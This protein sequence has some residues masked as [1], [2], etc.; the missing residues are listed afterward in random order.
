MMDDML[1]EHI[2]Q[3]QPKYVDEEPTYESVK[4]E[5]EAESLEEIIQDE[6]D[7]RNT[8]MRWMMVEEEKSYDAR[9][10]VDNWKQAI[11]A[12]EILG[13]PKALQ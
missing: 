8:K 11:I 7:H 10:K 5:S 6:D 9:F 12:A 4:Y 2:P 13:K 1:K 3:R